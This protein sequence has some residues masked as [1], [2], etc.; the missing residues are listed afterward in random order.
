MDEKINVIQV[1]VQSAEISL[2]G[3]DAVPNL[4]IH[5]GLMN[6]AR[7]NMVLTLKSRDYD[8]VGAIGAVEIEKSRP[9]MQA[10]AS[11]SVEQFNLILNFIKHRPPRPVTMLL[12]LQDSLAVT[13][14][15]YLVAHS[16]NCRMISDLSWIIPVL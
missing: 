5:G 6:I 2:T 15:G 9:V 8:H 3:Q 7:G 12:A 14:E 1:S 4:V 11:L 13:S 16:Q 10:Q